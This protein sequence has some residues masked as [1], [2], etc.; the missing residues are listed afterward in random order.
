MKMD[1]ERLFCPFPK[2]SGQADAITGAAK[3]LCSGVIPLISQRQNASK[4]GDDLNPNEW[5]ALLCAGMDPHSR[6]A[7]WELLRKFKDDRAI[8][9]TTVG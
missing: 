8:V 6:R 2:R 5:P 9:L 3:S 4:P 1:G 7:M